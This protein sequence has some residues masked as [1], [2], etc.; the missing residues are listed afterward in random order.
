[1]S[2]Q[3]KLFEIPGQIGKS[4]TQNLAK[5]YLSSYPL[6][7][8]SNK[9]LKSVQ[10]GFSRQTTSVVDHSKSE[11]SNLNITTSLVSWVK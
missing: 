11:V 8:S 4:A 9:N 2:L 3:K 10:N 7:L 1:M 6:F 5:V